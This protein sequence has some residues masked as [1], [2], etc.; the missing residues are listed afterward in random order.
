MSKRLFWL[1]L[2]AASFSHA[3]E[4]QSY[5]KAVI[6]AKKSGKIIMI[7]A[8]RD[9]CHYCADMERNVFSDANVSA[10]IEARFI[11]VKINISH[12]EMPLDIDVMMT[13]SFY[14]INRNE[15]EIK[16]IPGSWG[17][18]DFHSMLEGIK[19]E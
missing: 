17:W 7:D 10:W 6:E 18:E 15:E 16:K 13:P 1:G 2:L 8:V 5:E 9:G 12:Q 19:D 11:P 4:W 3:L 14:F